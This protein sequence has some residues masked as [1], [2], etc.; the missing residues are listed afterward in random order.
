M[1]NRYAAGREKAAARADSHAKQVAERL[2]T[3]LQA[4]TAPWQ[5]PWQPGHATRP[6]N[7]TTGKSYRGGNALWLMAQERSDPRWLTFKQAQAQGAQARK[8]EHGTPIEYWVREERKA[9]TDQEGKPILDA[10]GGKKDVVT[11][12]DRPRVMHFTVFNAE[13]VDGLPPLESKAA[14]AWERQARAEAVLANSG[15][16]IEHRNGD[17]AF[18]RPSTDTV[19]LPERGQFDSADKYYATAL[20]ELAHWTGAPERLHREGGSAFGSESYAK[21]ELRAEIGSMMIGDRIGVGHTPDADGDGQH[22]AYVASWIKAL[23]DDP[24][25]IFRAARDAE[26]IDE[27]VAAFDPEHQR[28]HGHDQVPAQASPQAAVIQREPT[29]P[30][31]PPQVS[32][33]GMDMG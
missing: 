33:G 4:G 18:Y 24:R 6:Y 1:T 2:I 27:Y 32:R 29:L 28:E 21:E 16:K 19:T 14:P 3:Q 22:A 12:L 10:G 26:K 30:A 13:Q 7:P 20:H 25:E 11:Q 15:A 17:A 9:L 5:K 23:Q 31:Q 8:G